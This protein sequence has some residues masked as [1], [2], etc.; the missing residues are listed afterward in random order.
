MAAA[1][2]YV[3]A[4]LGIYSA[5]ESHK[6]AVI[7]RD[8]AA[9]AQRLADLQ[10][11]AAR[12]ETEEGIDRARTAQ[13]KLEGMTRARIAASGVTATGSMSSY[14]DEMMT[15]HKGELDWMEKAGAT[16]ADVA[17]VEGRLASQTALAGA[18]R[19]QASAIGSLGQ[20][21]TSWWK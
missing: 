3:V 11:D 21:A 10:A 19:S 6:G 8:A 13:E 18:R 9:E 14:L 12:A 17:A 4:A 15:T 20:A 16:R 7:Q 5:S 2:P 1:I